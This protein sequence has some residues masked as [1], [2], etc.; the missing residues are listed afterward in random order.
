MQPNDVDYDF[1]KILKKTDNEMEIE[2]FLDIK[3][4][5][6]YRISYI[7]ILIAIL[8]MLGIF[9]SGLDPILKLFAFILSLFG[10]IPGLSILGIAVY[11]LMSKKYILINKKENFFKTKTLHGFI[12]QNKRFKLGNIIRIDLDTTNHLNKESF[13]C[14]LNFDPKKSKRI[15]HSSE[16]DM[17]DLIEI[18]RDFIIY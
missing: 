18:L 16:L 4:R 13:S 9:I 3:S 7:F 17:I 10:F 15:L 6:F 2:I 5:Y 8:L 12:E 14:V 1:F 11:Y